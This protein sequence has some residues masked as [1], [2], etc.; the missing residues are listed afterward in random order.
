[1]QQLQVLLEMAF[2]LLARVHL[3]QLQLRSMACNMRRLMFNITRLRLMQ[4]SFKRQQPSTLES[5]ET[6][7]AGTRRASRFLAQTSAPAFSAFVF[8]AACVLI[9]SRGCTSRPL[10]VMA[11]ARHH[12]VFA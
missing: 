5:G 7:E 9:V 2:L 6:R 11:Q 10:L 1:M 4:W 3:A 12:R 8:G